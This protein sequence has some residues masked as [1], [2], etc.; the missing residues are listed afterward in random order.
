MRK[1][2]LCLKSN[3]YIRDPNKRLVQDL[4]FIRKMR[5]AS[6]VH[7]LLDWF[8]VPRRSRRHDDPEI[9]KLVRDGR[10]TVAQQNALEWELRCLRCESIPCGI[11]F[12][13][14]YEFRCDRADCKKS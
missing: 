12:K 4:T 2:N 8:S 3:V 11:T 10:L 6:A 5:G 1:S 13:G 9:E 7:K 14:N